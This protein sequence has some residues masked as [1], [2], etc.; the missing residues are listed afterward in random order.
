MTADVGK[1][2]DS[3]VGSGPPFPGSASI[4]GE[5]NGEVGEEEGD[6]T[7]EE[8]EGRGSRG[9]APEKSQVLC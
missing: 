2:A 9:E 1:P 8:G 4:R 6:D 5:G 7:R 3:V